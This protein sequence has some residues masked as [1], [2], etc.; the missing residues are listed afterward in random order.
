MKEGFFRRDDKVAGT[1]AQC[2]HRHFG[3]VSDDGIQF[4]SGRQRSGSVEITKKTKDLS[5]LKL[6]IVDLVKI[7]EAER[8][9]KRKCI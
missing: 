8:E 7:H 5:P 3:K 2:E 4:F 9:R 1:K 6:L